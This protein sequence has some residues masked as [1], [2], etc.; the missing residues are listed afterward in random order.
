[1]KCL[2]CESDNPDNQKFCG[3]CGT[4]ISPLEDVQSPINIFDAQDSHTGMS[5]EFVERIGEEAGFELT[6]YEQIHGGLWVY[7][8]QLL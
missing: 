7:V 1:M 8:L 6:R 4:Q 2:K 3:E 5:R